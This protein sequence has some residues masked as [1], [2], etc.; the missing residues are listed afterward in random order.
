[1][2]ITFYALNRFFSSFT[3]TNTGR[4]I[5]LFAELLVGLVILT[6]NNILS[7][8]II[9]REGDSIYFLKTNPQSVVK[10]IWVKLFLIYINT[11]FVII[12]SL[13]L[14]ISYGSNIGSSGDDFE[15]ILMHLIF[16]FVAII[17]AIWSA[18][19]DITSPDNVDYKQT[20][21]L[22]NNKN[23]L[24][25]IKKGIFMSVSILAIFLILKA[26][27]SIFIAMIIMLVILLVLLVVKIFTINLKTSVYLRWK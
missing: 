4:D 1:M 12:I 26:I 9:S 7:A 21:L 18:E 11:I 22:D 27:T 8:S 17:H 2:P 3:L 19:S 13:I 25:S 10:H 23:V 20:G 6:T 14:N 5:L 24:I 15:I 16:F